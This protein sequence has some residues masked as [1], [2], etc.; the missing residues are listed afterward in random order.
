MT[1][2]LCRVI[3]AS[4]DLAWSKASNHGGTREIRVMCR[5]STGE[6]RGLIASAVLSVWLPVK[7]AA[8]FGF[9]ADESRRHEWDLMM[10]GQSVQSYVTVRKGEGR[11]NRVT[12]YVSFSSSPTEPLQSCHVSCM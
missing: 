12:A 9:L 4:R 2:S 1:S 5:K 3:G 6:P 7:P 8:L 11:G 10:P